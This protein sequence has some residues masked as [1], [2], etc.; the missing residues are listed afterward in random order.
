M[1]SLASLNS[2]EADFYFLP[3]CCIKWCLSSWVSLCRAVRI[4][5]VLTAA[6]A[7]FPIR[8]KTPKNVFWPSDL[9]LWPLTLIFELDLDILPLDLHA[10][11]QVRMSV[12]SARRVVT[13]THTHTDRHTHRH[14][15]PKLLHPSL[16]RGVMKCLAWLISCF[17]FFYVIR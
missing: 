12:R 8:M 4:S 10:K 5:S 3:P 17:F 15:V 14:T 7:I 6:P 9:D 2:L 13:H 1:W 16:T 11:I